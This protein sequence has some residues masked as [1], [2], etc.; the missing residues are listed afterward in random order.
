MTV[1]K[2]CWFFVRGGGVVV[3]ILTD[4]VLNEN[5]RLLHCVTTRVWFC[6][7]LVFAVHLIVLCVYSVELTFRISCAVPHLSPL[8]SCSLVATD[9]P[10]LAGL[11]PAHPLREKWIR[12]ASAGD[13]GQA[14]RRARES[15]ERNAAGKYVGVFFIFIVCVCDIGGFWVHLMWSFSDQPTS[16]HSVEKCAFLIDR[17][18]LALC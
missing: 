16:V 15:V 3:D 10:Q 2:C 12:A 14:G 13:G 1:C 5:V 4:A 8:P 9:Q 7:G 11:F 6:C 17:V 18:S